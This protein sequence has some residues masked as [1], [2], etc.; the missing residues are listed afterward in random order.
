MATEIKA[1]VHGCETCRPFLASQPNQPLI[2]GTTATGPMTDVGSDLF[3]IGHNY[4]LVMV[5]RY[6]GCPFVEKLSKL[7]TSAIIK[8]LSSWFNTFGWPE[9]I[10]SDNGPQY[11]SEFDEFCKE[12]FIIHENSSP[13][14][15]Q[16]NGLSEAAVKQMKFLLKKVNENANEFSSRLLDFRNTPNASGKSPAQMFFGR[17]L[18]GRL[19]HLPGANDL[20]IGNA[21]DGANQRKLLMETVENR[22]GTPLKPLTSGQRV[23][24]QNPISKSWDE[25]GIIIEVRP[26]GRS[27][28]VNMDSGKS[29]VRNRAF[30]RP[31]SDSPLHPDSKLSNSPPSPNEPATLRRSSRLAKTT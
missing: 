14:Y 23:L 7:S 31:I 26:D 20:D 10:R 27:Y 22:S 8:V 2:A 16:S 24:V 19:P 11:R 17:R 12:N 21:I 30:L 29:F 4:Y 5:D 9:R 15:P 6:S 13:Y 18:R 25:K 3:Q 1:L 28:E